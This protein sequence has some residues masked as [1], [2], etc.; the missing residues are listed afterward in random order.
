MT[1]NNK[2]QKTPINDLCKQALEHYLKLSREACEY[3][4]L[5]PKAIEFYRGRHTPPHDIEKFYE[6]EDEEA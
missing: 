2:P 3:N 6:V 4:S 1:I 5:I